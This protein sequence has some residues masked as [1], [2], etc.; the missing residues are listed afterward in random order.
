MPASWILSLNIALLVLAIIQGTLVIGFLVALARRPRPG[1]D[2]RQA[3]VDPSVPTGA[4][5]PAARVVLCVRGADPSL[6]R[7]AEAVARLDYPSYRLMVV[8]DNEA[9]QGLAIVREAL[10]NRV[11]EIAQFLIL[12]DADRLESCSMKCSA[13]VLACRDLAPE[14]RV[15]ATIDADTRPDRDWLKQLVA[16]M[17]ADERVGA[18]T[19][20]RWYSPR[21][22][23]AGEWTR[24]VWNAAAIVQMWAYGIPWGGSMAIRRELLSKA[25]LLDRWQTTFCEDTPTASQLKQHGYRVHT[26][27]FLIL[28]NDERCKLGD[29]IPWV[30]RQLLTARLHHPA[31]GLVL[32]HAISTTGIPLLTLLL[33]LVML[34]L[35]RF[36]DATWLLS[37]FAIYELL[38]LGLVIGIARGVHQRLAESSEHRE[39]APPLP[40]LLAALSIGIVVSQTS[41]PLAAFGATFASG[42]TW[43][44]IRYAILPRGRIQRLNYAPFQH[45]EQVPSQSL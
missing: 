5:W 24:M 32:S 18:T 6:A 36:T 21:G 31:W 29:V 1:Q 41:Y 26:I 19:G 9:D 39:I 37:G 25:G 30:K 38:M 33:G 43:R 22:K 7:C 20:V 34:M 27:P 4:E 35:Q 12:E 10:G 13:L 11:D 45:E 17:L 3:S 23:S 14:V 28:D 44:Q 8:A 15:V 16:P 42:V 40:A 2:S